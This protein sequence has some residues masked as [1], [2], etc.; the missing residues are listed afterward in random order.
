M[1]HE[2]D[3]LKII[4]SQPEWLVVE[5]KLEEYLSDMF[6]LRKIDTSLSATTYKAECLARLRAAENVMEFYKANHFVKKQVKELNVS[7]R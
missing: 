2:Y 5:T 7:F 3:A 1:S 4:T 6:D